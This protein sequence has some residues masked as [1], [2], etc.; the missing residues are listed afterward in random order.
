[1]VKPYLQLGFKGFRCDAAYKIPAEL[2]HYLV[3][4][5]VTVDTEAM[6]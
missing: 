2:W 5:A 6:V 3:E 4:E 1:M